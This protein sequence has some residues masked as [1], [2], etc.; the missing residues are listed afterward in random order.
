MLSLQRHL[1]HLSVQTGELQCCSL[2]K[3]LGSSSGDTLGE[4][5][6]ETCPNQQEVLCTECFTQKQMSFLHAGTARKPDQQV[7]GQWR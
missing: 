6:L 2:A 7:H 3:T 5:T 4:K 1:L